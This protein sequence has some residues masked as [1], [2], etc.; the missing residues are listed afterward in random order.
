M[1]G[2]IPVSYTGLTSLSQFYIYN[3]ALNRT[4]TG[5][6]VISTGLSSWL[7][8]VTTKHY[9]GQAD[10]TAPLL[11]G[12]GTIPALVTGAISYSLA[13]NENSYPVNS[14]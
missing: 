13:I 12:T 11:S 6:A 5:Y 14:T 10:I 7:Q 4:T 3:N 8:G 2:T 1:I 9:H